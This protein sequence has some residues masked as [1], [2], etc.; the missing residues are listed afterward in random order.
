[1]SKNESP[2]PDKKKPGPAADTLKIEGGWEEA[3]KKAL[4]KKR[5]PQGWPKPDQPKKE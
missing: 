5:P 3:A 4:G 2:K 1:M